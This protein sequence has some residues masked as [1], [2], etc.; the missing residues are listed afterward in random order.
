MTMKKNTAIRKR[1]F[2]L[3]EIIVVIAL[4]GVTATVG[5]K[6]I[7]SLLDQHHFQREVDQFKSLLQELQIEAL[8]LGSDME[9]QMEKDDHWKAI[10]KSREKILQSETIDLKHVRNLFLNHRIANRFTIT[11]FSTGRISPEQLIELRGNKSS[12]W[13]DLREPIQIK[14][15][16]VKPGDIVSK[17]PPKK[18]KGENYGPQELRI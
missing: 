7:T 16:T 9:L 10:F 5:V 13:V 6:A 8:T 11:I 14:F 15:T 1:R 4:V 17:A 12:L 2:T 3:L 18:S